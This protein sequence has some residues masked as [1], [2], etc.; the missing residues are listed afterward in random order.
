M[1]VVLLHNPTAGDERH[2]GDELI[3]E[4]RR[5]GHDVTYRAKSDEWK[6][7]LDDRADVV[8]VAGGDGTIRQVAIELAE[9]GIG[10][11]LPMAILPVGTANNLAQGL[12]VSGDAAAL[13]DGLADAEVRRLAV[14]IAEA[15]WGQTRFV[16]SAGIGAFAE[17]LRERH[18]AKKKSRKRAP[19]PRRRREHGRAAAIQSG[20][21]HLRR[22][23]DVIA[24]LHLRME[25][26]GRDLT[27]NY[28]LAEAMNTPSIGSCVDL[29][30]RAGAG[31]DWL[32]LVLVRPDQRTQ[33]NG[34]LED[35]ACHKRSAPPIA[36]LRVRRLRMSWPP[37]VGHVDDRP[38]PMR[39]K[40]K[41]H[42][43]D[44]DVTLMI[45]R[46]L[47]VLVVRT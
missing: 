20:L 21:A 3:H 17:M 16:E 42:S 31:D 18:P 36:T 29:A 11:D 25:A 10:H 26:D 45:D 1:R 27:G 7:A 9:R 32:D 23:L 19:F 30:P 37:T 15:P 8:I 44:A 34:Y 13:A 38:W 35:Q 40:K 14:G 5:A 24:P 28:L 46:L 47:P 4:F 33:M 22:T 43:E 2:A 12:G 39:T 6:K 41:L